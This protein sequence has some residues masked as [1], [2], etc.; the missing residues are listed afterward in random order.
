[1]HLG[2][3]QARLSTEHFKINRLAPTLTPEVP[4]EL[5]APLVEELDL[6]V[7]KS[8]LFYIYQVGELSFR[9]DSASPELSSS[10][11]LCEGNP[12][13]PA[14][15]VEGLDLKS[16]LISRKSFLAIQSRLVIKSGFLALLQSA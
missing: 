9:L 2:L 7:L 3:Q 15:E 13:C 6:G 14:V 16:A 8:G 1:V 4:N 11:V 5:P 12:Y 10:V